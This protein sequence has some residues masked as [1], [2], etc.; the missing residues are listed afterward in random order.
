MKN[1][2]LDLSRPVLA[3]LQEMYPGHR[4]YESDLRVE[5]QLAT[6]NQYTFTILAPDGS[7][8]LL[9]TP[10]EIRLNKSDAFIGTQIGFGIYKCAFATPTAA[11]L[12]AT[13]L[14][15]F[16]NPNIYTGTGEALNLESLYT[17]GKI[18]FLVDDDVYMDNYTL[19]RMRKVGQ[20]QQGVGSTATNNL[21]VARD[22]WDLDTIPVN[23]LARPFVMNGNS[24]F[25]LS[26]QLQQAVSMAG[27]SS[28]NYAVILFRG[29][30]AVGI[31]STQA[32]KTIRN[33]GGV[34]RMVK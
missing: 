6:T 33:K 11:Q 13:I 7:S 2:Q 12:V 18:K 4:I 30:L 3:Q 16:P 10:N 17:N 29:Y 19:L 21:P 24:K 9:V 23:P 14:N 22:Q 28:Q 15:A 27:T 1:N 8:A 31:N 20:S 26:I 34:K 32:K 5:V 25:D